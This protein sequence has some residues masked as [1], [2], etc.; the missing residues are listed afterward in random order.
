MKFCKKII[1][2]AVAAASLMSMTA[3]MTVNQ[4]EYDPNKQYLNIVYFNGG[5]VPD[6]L[7]V[8]EKEYEAQHENKVDILINTDEKDQ[9]RD[10]TL[11]SMIS[12]RTEE[13]F[14]T[15]TLNYK[16]YAAS[17]KIVD[18]SDIVTNPAAEG[19]KSIEE[20]MDP[21][22]RKHYEYEED[23]YYAVPF[24]DNFYGAIY[25]VDLFENKRLYIAKDGGYT[26]GL[27]GAPEKSYGRDGVPKTSDDGLPATF[28][29]YKEWLNY[30]RQVSEWEI[31]Q[32]LY[33]I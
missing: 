20:R 11:Y 32:Y 6:W 3:C 19:E 12:F 24:Y 4:G 8:L 7:F 26:S 2:V 10:S 16:N 29:E 28:T 22:L 18:I 13:I 31:S 21:N 5:V 30:M 25:D 9:L 33:K 23:T 27:D 17:G 15:H 14:F 1:A